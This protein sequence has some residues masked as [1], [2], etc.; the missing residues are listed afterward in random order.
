MAE[1]AGTN[2]AEVYLRRI[3]HVL[4]SPAKQMRFDEMIKLK[5]QLLTITLDLFTGNFV[6]WFICEINL[7]S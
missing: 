5:I 3:I 7:L 6:S 2:T 1:R 4:I